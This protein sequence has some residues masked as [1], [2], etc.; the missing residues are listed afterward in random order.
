MLT[1]YENNGFI[2]YN[3]EVS[4]T[5]EFLKHVHCQIHPSYYPEGISNVCLEAAASGR[6]VIT[7]NRPGCRE[8]VDNEIT[9]YI[10]EQKNRE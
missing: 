3:G 2:K 5:A 7:T 9:G 4:D 10:F 1:E 8:T 6:P